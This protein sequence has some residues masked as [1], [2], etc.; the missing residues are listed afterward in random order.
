MHVGIVFSQADSGTDASAI[1]QW[2]IDAEAA[3]FH[4]LMAY[5]HVLGG[6]VERL[7]SA[8]FGSFQTPPYTADHTFHEILSL[9][10]H[11]SAVT[12]AMRF[13]TSVLVLPQRQA[14]VA[15]K[16]IATV[17]LLSGSRIDV[18]V[19]VGWN[20]VE[21]ES[22]GADFS[23]RTA[24]LEEQIEVMRHLWRQPIVEFDGRFH[25][26]HGV[27]I[28][29]R[30]TRAIPILLG[31]GGSDPVL[32]RVV[33]VADG[34][35]PLLIPGLDPIPFAT[36]ARRLRELSD[37]AG[38][39]PATLSIHGRAYLGDGWQRNVEDAMEAGCSHLSFGFNRMLNPGFTHRQQ[40][41]AVLAAKPEL[42][43]LVGSP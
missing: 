40:L 11:L 10:S 7:M 24:M 38:R 15:A 43:A 16:Q 17:D 13:V 3:G 25:T 22:L 18:A 35:M 41:E 33:R 37:E 31:C 21:Y 30:P 27:G 6:T 19:G 34:W 39:D 29:P 36:A 14:A 4:H 5:D 26:L 12:T 42:D 32:R 1:R 8:R 2:A 23:Q 28:N 9:F 20:A